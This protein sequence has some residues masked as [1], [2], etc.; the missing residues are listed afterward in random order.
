MKSNQTTVLSIRVLTFVTGLF[1]MAIGVTLSVKANLGLSP[2]SC[3]PFV[4]SLKL[5]LTLGEL[6][7]L[8]NLLLIGLQVLILRKNYQYFQLIQLPAVTLFG[9]FIDFTMGIF[10]GLN[11]SSYFM[12][13]VLC[14]L[15]CIILAFG[16]FLIIKANLTYLPGEGL[17]VAITETFKKEFGKVKI[18]IDSSMV[19]LGTLSSFLLL[20]QLEGIREGTFAAAVLVG[21]M[22]RFYNSQFLRLQ[23]SALE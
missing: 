8:F 14:L 5:P 22:I 23:K 6:T 10:S 17:A 15:S 2:I 18:G 11:T 16:I 20:N 19:I 4:L 9:Y 13:I 12:Q 7:I 3:T 1:I 21:Y